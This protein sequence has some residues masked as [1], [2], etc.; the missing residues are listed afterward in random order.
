MN[1]LAARPTCLQSDNVAVGADMTN[2]TSPNQRRLKIQNRNKPLEPFPTGLRFLQLHHPF[3]S[4]HGLST[5]GRVKH[6]SHPSHPQPCGGLEDYVCDG[7]SLLIQYK[8]GPMRKAVQPKI[9][10][11]PL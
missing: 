11:G 4:E 1:C 6:P 3:P 2:V 9:Q 7:G 5:A 8:L 10:I